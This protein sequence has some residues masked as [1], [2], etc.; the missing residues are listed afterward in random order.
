MTSEE[1][2]LQAESPLER[3]LDDW[4]VSLWAS[5]AKDCLVTTSVSSIGLGN[6]LAGVELSLGLPIEGAGVLTT[7]G[8]G[9]FFLVRFC[10]TEL[11]AL[12]TERMALFP[13]EG[14]ERS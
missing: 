5:G 6:M 1:A 4:G 13:V 10:N 9:D 14:R 2:L 11:H 8:G 12:V 7:G 3:P